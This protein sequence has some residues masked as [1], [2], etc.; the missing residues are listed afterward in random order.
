MILA[1]YYAFVGGRSRA[2]FLN[3]VLAGPRI[4]CWCAARPSGRAVVWGPYI[5][6]R[7]CIEARIVFQPASPGSR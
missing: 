6:S 1:L 5:R 4:R 3:S 2:G 7:S